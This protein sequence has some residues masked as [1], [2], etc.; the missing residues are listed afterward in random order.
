MPR[1]TKEQEDILKSFR[2][3]RLSSNPDNLFMIDNFKNFRNENLVTRL[4]S[5]AYEEDEANLIAYYLVKNTNN[6]ILF[7]FSLK[8][9]HI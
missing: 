4:Q 7:Y 1:I 5:E 2:I 3:E 6:D 8:K 9:R